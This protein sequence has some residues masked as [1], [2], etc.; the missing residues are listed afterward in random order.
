LNGP[1]AEGHDPLV[2]DFY[3]EIHVWSAV[4]LKQ[5]MP[6]LEGKKV[7]AISAFEDSIKLQWKNRH[8]LFATGPDPFKYPEFEL[9]TIKAHNTIK[10]N[11]P[12]P[13][14]NWKES[15]HAMCKEIDKKDFDIAVI[16][17]G[18]YGMP[19]AH[20]VKTIGRGAIYVGS[21]IQI[22]FGIRGSRWNI[23]NNSIHNHFNEY[24]KNPEPHEIPKTFKNVEGGCYWL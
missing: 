1:A 15:F 2:K 14:K 12:F 17:A 4:R 23:K 22:M 3:D 11:E 8:K 6:F 18:G 16:G 9:S 13:C 7:L 21:Y 19:L 10:G 24:W 5:W 20:Y